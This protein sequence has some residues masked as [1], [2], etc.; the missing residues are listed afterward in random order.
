MSDLQIYQVLG[1]IFFIV[2]L[3]GLL[4]KDVLKKVLEDY[5]GSYGLIYLSGILTLFTGYV[6]LVSH[7]S[8][9]VGLPLVITLLGW[10]VFLK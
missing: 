3:G 9:A 1:L 2:G 10:T 4:R 8:W 6:I 7:H 5:A